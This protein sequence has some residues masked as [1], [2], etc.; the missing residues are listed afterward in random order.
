MFTFQTYD[1]TLPEFEKV[2]VSWAMFY[3][4]RLTKYKDVASLPPLQ[5][6]IL[7]RW[8][9]I[10]HYVTPWAAGIVLE[11][12]ELVLH[13]TVVT[14]RASLNNVP[15]IINGLSKIRLEPVTEEI[16]WQLEALAAKLFVFAAFTLSITTSHTA[17]NEA[18]MQLFTNFLS[19]RYVTHLITTIVST[20]VGEVANQLVPSSPL[21]ALR[22]QFF[23]T[24]VSLFKSHKRLSSFRSELRD[25]HPIYNVNPRKPVYVLSPYH[26]LSLALSPQVY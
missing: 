9:D 26:P 8:A 12:V 14:D 18:Y 5:Q 13:S 10:L 11:R 2:V 22:S 3:F 25:F 16:G 19:Q 6:E 7:W 24:I 4:Q 20:P 21:Y 17:L 1:G 15:I 23:D